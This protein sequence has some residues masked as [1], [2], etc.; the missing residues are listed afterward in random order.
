MN[1]NIFGKILLILALVTTTTFALDK[2]TL[3]S[4]MTNKMNQVVTILDN[5]DLNL[6][7][8]NIEIIKVMDEV[9]D[10]SLM[11]KIALGRN[12]KKIKDMTQFNEF[13]KAFENSLKKSYSDKLHL[14]DNQKLEIGD[15]APYKNGRLQLK[16]KV[17]GEKETYEI[18]YNFYENKKNSQWYIYDVELIGVSILQ[19]YI[20]QFDGVLA[21]NDINYLISEL[22][23]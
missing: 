20:K 7:T 5:K 18:N 1:K 4:D 19:T 22:N 17:V 21:N 2:E 3:K 15:L 16:T 14:Y 6:E 13:S 11:S 9:F 12:I 23:K 8:K 10:Y